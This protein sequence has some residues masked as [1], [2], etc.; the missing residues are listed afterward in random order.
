MAS[1]N[2]NNIINKVVY[3]GETLIDLTGDTVVESD[4][5]YGKIFH[6]S[7]GTTATGASTLDSDTS[8]AN[9]Q[10]AE[11]LS[12][13]TAYVGGNKVTGSMTNVGAQTADISTKAQQVT[14]TQG[15]HDGSGKVKISS[16]EQAK[17][18]AGNIKSGVQIL[19]VE[20]TYTG[21]ERIKA[22][23]GSG[24]PTT[25]SQIVLPSSSGDFDYFTQFTINA[26]PYTEV[27][28]AAGGYTATIA[29]SAS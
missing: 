28:N 16:T 6:K 23:T 2:S 19:G 5:Q 7:D 9:A 4:V 13:K 15:Y 12:G 3:D 1:H 20:G 8:D 18:I 21:S 10:A 24:T 22:T 11:I 29:G 14:I 17:I 26:I 27:L 25:S